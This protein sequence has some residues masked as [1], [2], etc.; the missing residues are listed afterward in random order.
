MEQKRWHVVATYAGKP[1]DFVLESDI[2]ELEDLSDAIESGPD[3]GTLKDIRITY[4]FHE[5]AAE[6]RGTALPS[7]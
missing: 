4:N 1:F 6:R 5:S 2:E 7:P 3:W